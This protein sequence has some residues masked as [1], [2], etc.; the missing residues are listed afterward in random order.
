MT[1]GNLLLNSGRY[2]EAEATYRRAIELIERHQGAESGRIGSCYNNIANTRY[3]RGDYEGALAH[4]RKGLE[5]DERVLGRDH[6]RVATELH[7][8]SLVLTLLGRYAEALPLETRALEI[9]ERVLGPRHW[10]T[11]LSLSNLGELKWR[12][13]QPDEAESLVRR[14]IAIDEEQYATE[15]SETASDLDL[16][17]HVSLARDRPEDARAAFERSL[18]IRERL[19]DPG[20][21][22]S[23]HIGL[24]EYHRHVGDLDQADSAFRRALALAP[25]DDPGYATVRFA[26]HAGLARVAVD[27]GLLTEARAEAEAALSA[28]DG[29]WPPDHPEVRELGDAIPAAPASPEDDAGGKS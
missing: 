21:T 17:G 13:G 22:A 20:E 27:R 15:K 9:R 26:A 16:L 10:H 24:G 12:L 29:L 8:I 5:I 6:Y 4:Y 19:G 23:G 3:F 7:N 18:A 25:A 14:A 28:V 2:D 11:A 1:H